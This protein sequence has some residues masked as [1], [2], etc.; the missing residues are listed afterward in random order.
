MKGEKNMNENGIKIEKKEEVLEN[1]DYKV[2]VLEIDDDEANFL[3][4]Y[5]GGGM[6]RV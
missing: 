4:C 2:D 3:C 6:E 1:K 5:V